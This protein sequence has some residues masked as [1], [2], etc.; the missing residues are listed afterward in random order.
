MP[1]PMGPSES[2]RGI[3]KGG[4]GSTIYPQPDEG[5]GGGGGG[6][7]GEGHVRIHKDERVRGSSGGTEGLEATRAPMP[8]AASSALPGLAA[9]RVL[10]LAGPCRSSSFA[11]YV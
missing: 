4:G 7:G 8:S 2:Y 5:G 6:G 10:P 11:T 9:R 1:I 3:R